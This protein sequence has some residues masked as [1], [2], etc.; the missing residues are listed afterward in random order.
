LI[1][2]LLIKFLQYIQN[3]KNTQWY[4]INLARLI[5]KTKQIEKSRKWLE[6]E[7]N[8]KEYPYLLLEI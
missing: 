6:L 3:A 8:F 5:I 2:T 4:H 7:T 1:S